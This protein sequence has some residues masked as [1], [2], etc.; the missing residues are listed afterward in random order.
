MFPFGVP[1]AGYDNPF[2]IRETHFR[3]ADVILVMSVLVYLRCTYRIFS[4]VQQ[5][6]PF[7]NVIRRKG[8]RPVRRP[9][10]HIAPAE[11][12][13]LLAG[14][15]AL[16]LI[17]QAAWWLVNALD[18]VPADPDFPLRWADKHVVRPLPPQR[19]A[20]RASSRPAPAGSS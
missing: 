7:E 4:I 9:A 16:V 19:P 1:E 15:G 8:D 6:M 11:F 14:A 10:A 12:A 13:W 18:F 17:G 3:V 2:E 5:S 20:R